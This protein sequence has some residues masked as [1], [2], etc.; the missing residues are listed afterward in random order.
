MSK[1]GIIRWE[2]GSEV[3]HD[4][5]EGVHDVREGGKSSW[6]EGG[7]ESFHT[8]LNGSYQKYLLQYIFL[9]KNNNFVR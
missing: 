4:G 7:S 3:V 8:L 9:Q 5:R 6:W 2:G 1:G